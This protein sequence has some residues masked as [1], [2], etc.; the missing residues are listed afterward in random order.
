MALFAIIFVGVA[1]SIITIAYISCL[2][3]FYKAFT[4]T[5]IKKS[6]SA[7]AMSIL[8]L[9]T[10]TLFLTSGWIYFTYSILN[11]HQ[12]KHN[13]LLLLEKTGT[14]CY[15][16]GQELMSFTFIYRIHFVF[17]GSP[18]QTSKCVGN[19]LYCTWFITFILGTFLG[20]SLVK[21][22]LQVLFGG[23]WIL[24]FFTMSIVLIIL[25]IH[26]MRRLIILSAQS[27]DSILN[28]SMIDME[29]LYV[30]IKNAILIPIAITSTLSCTIGLLIT[31][32]LQQRIPEIYVLDS[33]VAT[34]CLYLLFSFNANVYS[35]SCSWI[36]RLCQKCG[37]AALKNTVN[38]T[39]SIET[40]MISTSPNLK[41]ET[42]TVYNMDEIIDNISNNIDRPRLNTF[43]SD[44]V[45]KTRMDILPSMKTHAYSTS[46]PL[47]EL[48]LMK[49]ESPAIQT[50]SEL[51]QIEVKS[52]SGSSLHDMKEANGIQN[53]KL[54]MSRA[55]SSKV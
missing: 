31:S 40:T 48:N 1:V 3:S 24:T 4:S 33:L 16:Y 39:N 18:L 27:S 41:H 52:K 51:T 17:N 45:P 26:K 21:N 15:G 5:D 19:S 14:F 25:F 23:I 47:L 30:A 6:R 42:L 37:L 53:E 9:M 8:S 49:K 13:H 20:I 46:N 54:K 50:I 32:V 22:M 38:A 28:K 36:H 10:L 2:K 35:K 34:L 12:D 44:P 55:E 29:I 11:F 7:R 43:V